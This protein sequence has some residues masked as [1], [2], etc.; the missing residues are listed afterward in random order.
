MEQSLEIMRP[1]NRARVRLAVLRFIKRNGRPPT[2]ATRSAIRMIYGEE[3][4]DGFDEGV[5][6]G[7]CYEHD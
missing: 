6:L 3:I 5:D 1:V 7:M 4:V 2:E